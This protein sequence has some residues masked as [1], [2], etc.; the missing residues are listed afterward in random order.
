MSLR[1]TLGVR[2]LVAA[3]ALAAAAVF[4]P[5]AVFADGG[6][7]GGSQV[8]QSARFGDQSSRQSNEATTTQEQGSWNVNISPSVALFKDGSLAYMLERRD[9]EGRTAD[10]IAELLTTAFDQHCR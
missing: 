5:T 9:I 1:T 6:D 3:G 8:T 7:E 2:V 10:R 4:A